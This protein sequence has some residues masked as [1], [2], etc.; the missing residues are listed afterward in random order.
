MES[1]DSFRLIDRDV[2]VLWLCALLGMIA[3]FVPAHAEVRAE[4]GFGVCHHALAQDASW[5]YR[6]W[7]NY[8]NHNSIEPACYQLSALWTPVHVHDFDS[9][10]RFALVD[11][12]TTSANGNTYPV[13]EAAYFDSR[14]NHTAIT[15]SDTG[16][17]YGKGHSRGFTLG[18]VIE[19]RYSDFTVGAEVGM[20]FLYS[21]WHAYATDMN[22]THGEWRDADGWRHTP[23]LGAQLR[24]KWLSCSIRRY[25]DVGAHR[26]CQGCWGLTL[27]PVVQATIGM[28]I[29]L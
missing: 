14:T 27:G 10:L 2:A 16:V 25:Q 12:G 18:P 20:A 1:N 15:S 28:S 7:G 23:Y 17:V 9:G 11:L 29:P 26:A 19:R 5:S 8:Q 22:G 6:D 4:A 24:Y 21:T 13:N 3:V